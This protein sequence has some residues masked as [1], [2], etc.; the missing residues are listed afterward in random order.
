[1]T[2]GKKD[3]AGQRK[4]HAKQKPVSAFFSTQ[5]KEFLWITKH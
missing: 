1:M 2:C 5:A 4:E 3:S